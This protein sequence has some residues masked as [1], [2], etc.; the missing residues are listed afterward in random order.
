MKE[1]VLEKLANEDYGWFGAIQDE[2]F[3]NYNGD[4]EEDIDKLI[5]K[6]NNWLDKNKNKIEYLYYNS[7][8]DGQEREGV[9]KFNF[10]DGTNI[11]IKVVGTYSSWSSSTWEEV[12]EAKPYEFKETRYE[13][14]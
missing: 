6:W 1:I 5:E 9:L 14:V 7:N 13:R 12:Y 2:Y 10:E 3:D 11:I 8:G 4:D